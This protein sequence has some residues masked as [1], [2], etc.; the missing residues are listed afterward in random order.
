[1]YEVIKEFVCAVWS[2][3][4]EEVLYMGGG[5]GISLLCLAAFFCVIL[6][7]CMENRCVKLYQVLGKNQ[8]KMLGNLYIKE[9]NGRLFVTV[10]GKLLEK[11]ESVNYTLGIPEGFAKKHYM[12]ELFLELPSGRRRVAIK[13]YICFKTGLT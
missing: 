2:S 11:S 1:M 4:W 5:I 3:V 10:P 8:K 6:G 9:Q 12:E 13:R 7:I